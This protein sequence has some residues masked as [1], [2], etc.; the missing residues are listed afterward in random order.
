M[1]VIWHR[2]GSEEV[3]LI[4]AGESLEAKLPC[5]VVRQN[6]FPLLDA[7]GDEI[8]RRLFPT[9]PIRNPVRARHGAI[10]GRFCET[11]RV[12]GRFVGYFLPWPGR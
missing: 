1:Q 12:A 9:E 7:E 10:V 2:D 6:R 5:S 3:P 8:N 11:P 4:Q